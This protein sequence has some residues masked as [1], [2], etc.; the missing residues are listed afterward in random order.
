MK[1][2]YRKY[3]KRK[4][5]AA[6]YRFGLD[7]TKQC[8]DFVLDAPMKEWRLRLFVVRQSVGSIPVEKMESLFLFLN[9]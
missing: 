3:I 4:V 6:T 5:F 7:T 9:E 8:I 2:I 1:R